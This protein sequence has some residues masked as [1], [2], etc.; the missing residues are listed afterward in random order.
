MCKASKKSV[1]FRRILK[2]LIKNAQKVHD[3]NKD[4]FVF[5]K[6]HDY[7]LISSYSELLWVLRNCKKIKGRHFRRIGKSAK[8]Q[9]KCVDLKTIAL[10][11]EG[12]KDLR[13]VPFIS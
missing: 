10:Y 4:L 5:L 12:G 6:L 8:K 2:N 13:T 11:Y 1:N 7:G 9:N 3:G